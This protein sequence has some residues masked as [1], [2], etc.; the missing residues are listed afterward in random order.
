MENNKEKRNY[1]GSTEAIEKT[2]LPLFVKYGLIA[3]AS[4]VVIAVALVIYFSSAV[5]VVA[6][7][8]GEKI[9]EGEFKYYLEVQKQVM[10][11][12]ALQ[13][14]SN[15]T[16]ESFWA[17]KI[18]G[19]DA[20]EVAKKKA[21]DDLRNIKTQYKKAKEAKISLTKEEM[22]YIDDSIQ[23]EIIDTMGGGNKIKANNAFKEQYDFSMDV[24]REAQIQTFIVQK[25]R[26]DETAKITDAEIEEYYTKNTTAFKTD[27]SYRYGAEEAVWAKHILIIAG[28]DAS[29]E[30]KDAALKKAEELIDRL[31]SGEDFAALARENSED[32][33]SQWGGDYLFG[34]GK[35]VK[36]F[37]DSAFSLEPGQFTQAP[38]KT[39]FGYHIIKLEEKYEKGEAASLRCAKEY[40]EFGRRYVYDLKMKDLADKA[41][42][43]INNS[44]YSSIK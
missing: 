39:Q 34:K 36:E 26:E 18:G 24:L 16:E 20:V 41:E 14:D 4:I 11:Y 21:I 27:T 38:V 17:T 19:E 3:F 32:G 29:E 37:E 30:D 5:N 12:S 13:E 40:F 1:G 43:K 44:I 22:A 42:Y 35:M 7:I 23:R 28:E 9:T 25:Y 33:S 10:Y 31:K 8:D 6:T 2:G 15:I